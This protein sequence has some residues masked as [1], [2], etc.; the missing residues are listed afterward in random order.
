MMLDNMKQSNINHNNQQ[1]LSTTSK[2][3][4]NKPCHYPYSTRNPYDDGLLFTRIFLK[5][6]HIYQIAEKQN[7]NIFEKHLRSNKY[8]SRR[9]LYHSMRSAKIWHSRIN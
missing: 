8:S 3:I 1:I 2:S 6:K 9:R 5:R 7:K 4:H